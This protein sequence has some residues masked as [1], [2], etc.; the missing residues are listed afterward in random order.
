MLAFRGWGGEDEETPVYGTV[1]ISIKAFRFNFNK[2]Y[3][4]RFSN[5]IKKV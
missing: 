3:K 4:I 5:T 1:K 2:C